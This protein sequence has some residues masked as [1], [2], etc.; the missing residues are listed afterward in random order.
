MSGSIATDARLVRTVRELSDI[1]NCGLDT[2]TL[3]LLVE[4]CELGVNPN[5]LASIVVDLREERARLE[6]TGRK[7]KETEKVKE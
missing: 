4:L 3:K 5:D 1:L 7:T 2:E 6:R